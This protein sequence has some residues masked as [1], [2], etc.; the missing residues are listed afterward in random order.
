MQLSV[1]SKKILCKK[2]I[3]KVCFCTIIYY[4]LEFSLIYELLL[5]NASQRFRPLIYVS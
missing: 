4:V 3:A 2:E 1:N 5:A